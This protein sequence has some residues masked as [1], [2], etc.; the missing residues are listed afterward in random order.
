MAGPFDPL[1]ST[2][3]HERVPAWVRYGF[4]TIVVA[5]VGGWLLLGPSGA[6]ATP[7]V[8]SLPRTSLAAPAAGAGVAPSTTPASVVVQVAG[9][10]RT[11]GLYR[12]ASGAR[13]ADA[14]TAAGGVVGDGD[15]NGL[16][17]AARVVDGAR[18]FVPRVGEAAIASSD[19]AST[20][21]APIDVNS[22]SVE[23]LTALPGVG[24]ALAQAIVA[25]RA[26]HGPFPNVDAL[27]LV[28]GIG[29]AKLAAIRPL[30]SAS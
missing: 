17:L 7:V 9:A 26:R 16:N 5:L 27:S 11:P 24:P 18:I 22:A 25:Y 2:P 3:W 29:P 8:S 30:A 14:I 20:I 1:P 23:E 15:A 13:V 21:H 4:A 28:G 6:P 19:P 12:V 10:V